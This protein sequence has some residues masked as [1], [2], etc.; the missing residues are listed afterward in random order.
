MWGSTRSKR[1]LERSDFPIKAPSP[2]YFRLRLL[3]SFFQHSLQFPQGLKFFHRLFQGA[4][5][6]ESN[7]FTTTHR[8]LSPVE[9]YHNLSRPHTCTTREGEDTRH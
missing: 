9:T 8:N 3:R 5:R 2:K 1:S 6:Q 7:R 4:P